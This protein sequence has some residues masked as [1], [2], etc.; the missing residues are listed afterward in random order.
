MQVV[1]QA[2]VKSCCK[3]ASLFHWK[4]KGGKEFKETSIK[5]FLNCMWHT[6]RLSQISFKLNVRNHGEILI[7]SK[8][9][10]QCYHVLD[11]LWHS[12]TL[13]EMPP[14]VPFACILSKVPFSIQWWVY[15]SENWTCSTKPAASTFQNGCAARRFRRKQHCSALPPRVGSAVTPTDVG[16]INRRSSAGPSLFGHGSPLREIEQGHIFLETE[17]QWYAEANWNVSQSCPNA[18]C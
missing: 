13:S 1:P 5:T 9:K 14:E 7:L 2:A 8:W 17:M 11:H 16:A 4:N 18:K 15:L 10:I 6:S 12:K 3:S